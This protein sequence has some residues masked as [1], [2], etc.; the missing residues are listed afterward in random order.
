MP[1]DR[2]EP[3]ATTD[4]ARPHK[5]CAEFKELVIAD[6]RSECDNPAER[7]M[8]RSPT[9][10]GRW[11]IELKRLQ[12][13]TELHRSRERDRIRAARANEAL[14]ELDYEELLEAEAAYHEGRVRSTR[15]L[16][17]VEERLAECRDL[18]EISGP[19]R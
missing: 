6:V 14:G 8:L 2:T 13:S 17:E 7:Q 10:V 1:E 11:L 4:T 5:S 12:R 9:C 3:R 18:A 15:F 16:L 19:A